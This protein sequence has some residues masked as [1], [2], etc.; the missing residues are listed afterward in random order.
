MY[1]TFV[2]L[3]YGIFI[4]YFTDIEKETHTESS[5][6]RE[7]LVESMSED[8]SKETNVQEGDVDAENGIMHISTVNMNTKLLTGVIWNFIQW[9]DYTH[10]QFW[11]CVTGFNI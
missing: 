7:N 3:Y 5:D 10:M 8:K 9:T 4:W 2:I 1:P 6:T 11:T